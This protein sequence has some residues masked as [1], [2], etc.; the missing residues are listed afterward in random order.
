[1]TSD[2]RGLYGKF[3][4]TT[5]DGG[6]V[7]G[8]LFILRP[9]RDC[10][11]A[12]VAATFPE[13]L[14]RFRGRY[15][16]QKWTGTEHKPD[17]ESCPDATALPMSDAHARVALSFYAEL[18]EAENATLAEEIRRVVSPMDRVALQVRI[19]A[20]LAVM[21]EPEGAV[22]VAA[23]I[24][25]AGQWIVG[26]ARSDAAP[27]VLDSL[28]AGESEEDACEGAWLQIARRVE[29]EHAR[30][31]AAMAAALQVVHQHSVEMR[32]FGA[33]ADVMAPTAP[34]CAWR[35]N[36]NS[37]DAF[38]HSEDSLRWLRMMKR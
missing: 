25:D 12:T 17:M 16:V 6:E 23:R 21:K 30:C 10:H 29:A 35:L 4:V 24:D 18:C 9:E 22:S 11:A 20:L 14:A 1:M 19:N 27:C 34:P 8:R 37:R 38:G 33:I 2:K 26:V 3:H 5:P 28:A 13:V 31:H 32:W 15:V 7:T 36:R